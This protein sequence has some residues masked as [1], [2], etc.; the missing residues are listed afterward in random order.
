[1]TLGLVVL[2]PALALVFVAVSALAA[3]AGVAR[4]HL[5]VVQFVVRWRRKER[6]LRPISLGASVIQ[7]LLTV[8]TIPAAKLLPTSVLYQPELG[9]SPA[10][11]VVVVGA[12]LVLAAFAYA[13]WTGRLAASAPLEQ[14]REAEEH[15]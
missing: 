3:R 7:F 12:S 14:Q 15:S 4:P 13:S 11:L 9:P 1:V 6:E 5:D 2:V 8:F 10:A